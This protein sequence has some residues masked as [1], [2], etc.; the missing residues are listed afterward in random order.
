MLSQV[1]AENEEPAR[2][3]WPNGDSHQSGY[4]QRVMIH[5]QQWAK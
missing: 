2:V 4:R 1:S 5:P 3:S